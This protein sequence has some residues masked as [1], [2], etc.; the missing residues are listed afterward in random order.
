[1]DLLEGIVD[2]L[3]MYLQD[4][5][6]DWSIYSKLTEFVKRKIIIYSRLV[7]LRLLIQ[8]NTFIGDQPRTIV[9]KNV[10][11]ILNQKVPENCMNL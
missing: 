1:M 11:R 5:Y 4:V 3:R 7:C 10:Q 8:S 9:V 2:G 6:L